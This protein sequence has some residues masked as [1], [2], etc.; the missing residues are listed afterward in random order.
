MNRNLRL[1]RN[2]LAVLTVTLCF[3]GL[4]PKYSFA[5]DQDSLSILSK[6]DVNE[7][8]IDGADDEDQGYEK[9]DPIAYTL[10]KE[11]TGLVYP[12][13]AGWTT[14]YY[15]FTP[16]KTGRYNFTS[17]VT[18]N[19]VEYKVVENP[20]F[21]S[22]DTEHMEWRSERDDQYL[23]LIAGTKYYMSAY[24]RNT[25][26]EEIEFTF[27][28]A[29]DE[30]YQ[31]SSWADPV[32]V[33]LGKEY[34]ATLCG[35][36]RVE[37]YQNNYYKF[38]L[39]EAGRLKI[40]TVSP[41]TGVGWWFYDGIESTEWNYS[42][43]NTE[44]KYYGEHS[45]TLDL[46]A[47]TYY[48]KVCYDESGAQDKP[49]SFTMS[50]EPVEILKDESGIFDTKMSG[51]NNDSDHADQIKV[52]QKYVA[53][54]VYKN[55]NRDVP[56][57]WFKF[58]LN[59][60][61][62]L[63]L[64]ASTA[65]IDELGFVVLSKGQYSESAV[66]KAYYAK[67]SSPLVGEVL[68]IG[69]NT[70]TFEK[71]TYY[72]RVEKRKDSSSSDSLGT[73][74]AYRF[75]ISTG[76]ATPV[77]SVDIYQK[78]TKVTNKTVELTLNKTVE[79]SA[80]VLPESTP[81]KSV[82]WSSDD[83]SI[84]TINANGIVTGKKVGSCTITATTN[85]V[86]SSGDKLTASCTVEVEQGGSD[87]EDPAETIVLV[88]KQK[89]DLS[90]IF[91]TLEN[92]QKLVVDPKQNGS[93]T[94]KGIFTAKK[95]GE[96]LVSKWEKV[97]RVFEETDESVTIKIVKPQINYQVND[98][99]K[100][101]KTFTYYKKGEEIDLTELISCEEGAADPVFVCSD[102]KTK[103]FELDGSTLT[104]KNSGSCKVYV[105][106]GDID[107]KLAVKYTLS[108]KSVLPKL[109]KE[110][111]TVKTEKTV[112]LT[113]SKVQKGLE[114]EWYVGPENWE[115]YIEVEV[116]NG[117]MKLAITGVAPGEVVIYAVVDD[118]EYPCTVTVK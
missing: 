34:S 56:Y 101:V 3:A 4:L 79:L 30:K 2:F 21:E 51:S 8:V 29:I 54:S 46:I 15:T 98:N 45:D 17:S 72:L 89:A 38:T 96:V 103:N 68:G 70:V 59:T 77:T 90:G 27:K 94:K 100:T 67:P 7:A 61:S 53:Q 92:N 97:G 107:K 47:G 118:V 78:T 22:Y 9:E 74:G 110:K 37:E 1:L 13:D 73:A 111:L 10:G 87:P 52:G 105:Y 88:E 12:G 11:E 23:D 28:L 109:S 80:T 113:L 102:K 82:T 14:M 115:D 26:A 86:D 84:A 81:D 6:G 63:Y 65:Q 60:T 104:V 18:S 48:L 112:R 66:T 71:G 58:T 75:I 57:D 55:Y 106:Y 33:E 19:E 116:L 93:V 99:G 50:F 35:N 31:M 41:T 40:D 36:F 62:K 24:G 91:G 43:C 49:Y 39:K 108:I 85:G 83:T 64:S 114:P 16:E 76:A 95:E 5:Q 117:G 69:D 32:Q 44:Y 20:D 25:G 42:P